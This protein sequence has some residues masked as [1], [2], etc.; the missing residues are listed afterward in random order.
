MANEIERLA[1]S[2]C[3]IQGRDTIFFIVKSKVPQYKKVNIHLWRNDEFRS[4]IINQMRI[5][6]AELN[7]KGGTKS[8]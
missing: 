2:I 1:Q 6:T 4:P 3:D 5:T 7:E 8:Q